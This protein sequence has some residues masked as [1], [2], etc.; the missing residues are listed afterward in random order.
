MNS[1]YRLDNLQHKTKGY[2]LINHETVVIYPSYF[3]YSLKTYLHKV[4]IHVQFVC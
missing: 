1:H 2:D 3:S 4:L